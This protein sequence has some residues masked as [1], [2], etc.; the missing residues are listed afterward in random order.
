MHPLSRKPSSSHHSL[1]LSLSLSISVSRSSS[2]F[3]GDG[4]EADAVGARKR[5][6]AGEG[7]ARREEDAGEDGRHLGT[8]PEM[9]TY[10]QFG[11]EREAYLRFRWVLWSREVPFQRRLRL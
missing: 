10:P 1:S 2:G 11:E 5:E 6:R 8:W 7:D 4:D 3:A 9:G